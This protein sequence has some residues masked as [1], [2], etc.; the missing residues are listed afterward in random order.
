MIYTDSSE[1]KRVPVVLTW[2]G[3][4]R[5]RPRAFVSC[6]VLPWSPDRETQRALQ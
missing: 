4:W 5:A 3:S 1:Y 2:S 6:T